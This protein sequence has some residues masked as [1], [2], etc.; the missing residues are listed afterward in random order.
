MID[1]LDDNKPINTDK[2]QIL[3]KEE[4]KEQININKVNLLNEE[5]EKIDKIF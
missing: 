4:N 5:L 1:F 2:I 3:N